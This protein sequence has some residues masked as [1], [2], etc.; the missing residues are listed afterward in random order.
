MPSSK[1]PVVPLGSEDT[2]AYVPADGCC[3]ALVQCRDL[4]R[5]QRIVSRL[6]DPSLPF[7]RRKVYPAERVREPSHF[8]RSVISPDSECPVTTR[9]SGVG[10]EHPDAGD[11]VDTDVGEPETVPIRISSARSVISGLAA[12]RRTA[13]SA[14]SMPPRISPINTEPATPTTRSVNN[15]SHKNIRARPAVCLAGRRYQTLRGVAALRSAILLVLAVLDR[16]LAE[17]GCDAL[18]GSRTIEREN[19]G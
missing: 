10:I 4:G 8:N 14:S 7:P 13:P 1:F 5:S 11:F 3:S 2:L 18:A 12:A 9:A 16:L 19:D 6:A 17:G 15:A